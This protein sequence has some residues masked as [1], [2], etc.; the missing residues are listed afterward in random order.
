MTEARSIR[1]GAVAGIGFVLIALV[2]A[3]LPGAPPRADGKAS[4]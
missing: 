2:A 1:I 4:A 3:A